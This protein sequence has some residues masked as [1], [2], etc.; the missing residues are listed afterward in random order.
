MNLAESQNRVI[1]K[2]LFPWL[3]RARQLRSHFFVI[4]KVI[5]SGKFFKKGLEFFNYVFLN[6][7][8]QNVS[9]EIIS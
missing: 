9:A 8:S 3:R 7:F 2:Q 4:L 5:V 6:I 1:G